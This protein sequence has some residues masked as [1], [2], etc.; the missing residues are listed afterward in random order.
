MQGEAVWTITGIV[1]LQGVA[2]LREGGGHTRSFLDEESFKVEASRAR[3]DVATDL[4]TAAAAAAAAGELPPAAH[5][6]WGP[7][8]QPAA[9]AAGPGGGDHVVAPPQARQSEL[10]CSHFAPIF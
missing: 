6:G 2:G 10:T 7:D 3:A 5:R 1:K 4:V 9:A 8:E